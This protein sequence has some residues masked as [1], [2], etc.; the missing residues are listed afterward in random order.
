MAQVSERKT[1]RAA[2][3]GLLVSARG[4]WVELPEIMQLA[5][6]YN[7]RIFELRRLGFKIE[8]RIRD[9]DG[10]RHSWFRLIPPDKTRLSQPPYWRRENLGMRVVAKS[11]E[12]E[13]ATRPMATETSKH[14]AAPRAVQQP[15]FADRHQDD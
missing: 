9:V 5:A 14:V 2:I 1:Q 6:Q 15:L 3:L 13:I 8:N 7:T 4:Q 10:I 12:P 11:I